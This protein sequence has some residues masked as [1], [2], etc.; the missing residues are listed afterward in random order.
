MNA[1]G[2]NILNSREKFMPDFDVTARAVT[3][4]K[5]YMEQNNVNSALRIAMMQGGCSGPSLK[6]AMD[7]PKEND[8]TFA[9]D[10]L[11]FLVERELLKACGSIKVEYIDAGPSSGFVITSKI[12][13]PGGGCG[14][15]CSSGGCDC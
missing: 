8:R 14:G 11:K 1:T 10:G 5:E 9:N 13:L 7:E 4:L 12:P 2:I 3:K 6:L 15:S